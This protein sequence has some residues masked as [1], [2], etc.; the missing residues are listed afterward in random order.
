MGNASRRRPH[1]SSLT[2][3]A[4]PSVRIFLYSP[5]SLL[6]S[7]SLRSGVTRTTMSYS[8]MMSSSW[9]SI[10]I[11]AVRRGRLNVRVPHRG[12]DPLR[13]PDAQRVDGAF[14]GLV[15]EHPLGLGE[16][17]EHVVA[18]VALRPRVP[19][20]ADADAQPG[21]LHRPEVGHD[22]AEPLLRA[23]RPAGPHPQVAESQ[24][25]LVDHDAQ[26][27]RVDVMFLAK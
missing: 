11:E 21:K 6:A 23:A 5:A 20:A 8:L 14:D 12:L 22:G 17:L 24:V 9:I 4:P 15:E 10:R 3:V 16:G 19:L 7:S 1:G 25:D 18:E 13:D 2:T 27:L 26:R